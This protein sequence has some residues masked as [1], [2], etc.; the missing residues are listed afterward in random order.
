MNLVAV[1][2]WGP[3]AS[4]LVPPSGFLPWA[5]ATVFLTTGWSPGSVNRY[6]LLLPSVAFGGGVSH[7]DR[8]QTQTV[9]MPTFGNMV[10]IFFHQSIIYPQTVMHRLSFFSLTVQ[11]MEQQEMPCILPRIMLAFPLSTRVK[12]NQLWNTLELHF[13]NN[14]QIS[15]LWIN[16]FSPQT[17]IIFTAFSIMF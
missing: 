12:P 11:C 13:L 10:V 17:S 5:L 4:V 2:S 6:K 16:H 14:R 9:P 7:R 1:A 15:D 8:K 3:P